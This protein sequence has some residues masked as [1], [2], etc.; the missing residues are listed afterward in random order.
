MNK[1]PGKDD[2]KSAAP[3][4]RPRAT[5]SDDKRAAEYLANERTFLAWIRTSIAIISLGFVVSKFSLWLHELAKRLDPHAQAAKTGASLPIGVTMMALGGFLA[6][7]A[8]RRYWVVNQSISRSEVTPDHSLIIVV[9][10]MVTLLAL[11]MILYML[12]TAE[13]A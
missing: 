6:V 8:A 5:I 9:T 4:T 12:L 10:T 3:D 2:K 11:A 13:K 7:L 1:R